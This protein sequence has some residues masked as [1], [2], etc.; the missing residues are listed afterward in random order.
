MKEAIKV[1]FREYTVFDNESVFFGMKQLNNRLH[2][3]SQIEWAPNHHVQY[4]IGMICRHKRH[5]FRL[6]LIDSFDRCPCDAQWVQR[7]GPF[8]D[9]VDQPFYKTLVCTKDRE[10]FMS[11]AAQENLT[12]LDATNDGGAVQHPYIDRIFTGYDEEGG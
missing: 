10:P 8:E 12:P 3:I 4:D 11:I 5:H 9:G 2:C 6:V 1:S 7:Y